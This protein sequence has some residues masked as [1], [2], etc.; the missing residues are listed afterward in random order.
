M[1][2]EPSLDKTNLDQDDLVILTTFALIR[3][4]CGIFGHPISISISILFIVLLL[5]QGHP[6]VLLAPGKDLNDFYQ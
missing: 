6:G 2:N 5:S 1:G 4:P 3:N